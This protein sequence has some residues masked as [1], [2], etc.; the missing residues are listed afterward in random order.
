MDKATH[1]TVD[2]LAANKL[3]AALDLEATPDRMAL[4]TQH[5]ARHRHDQIGWAPSGFRL[6]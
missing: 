5:I 3:L 6:G 4:A 2:Q 1:W